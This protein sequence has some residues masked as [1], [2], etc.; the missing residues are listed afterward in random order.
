MAAADYLMDTVYQHSEESCLSFYYQSEGNGTLEV[1]QWDTNGHTQSVLLETNSN[2]K[3][4][5]NT[6]WRRM[7]KRFPGGITRL[8][9]RA[10]KTG[11]TFTARIDDV[12]FDECTKLCK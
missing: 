4:Q 2:D 12:T 5:I 3:Q 1:L 9:F 8:G 7:S 6:E 10:I 11:V